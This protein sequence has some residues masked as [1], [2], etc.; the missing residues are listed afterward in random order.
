MVNVNWEGKGRW[1]EKCNCNQILGASNAL[2]PFKLQ[3]HPVRSIPERI[4]CVFLTSFITNLSTQNAAIKNLV[5]FNDTSPWNPSFLVP[6]LATPVCRELE[7]ILSACDRFTFAGVENN[8]VTK[9]I[10]KSRRRWSGCAERNYTAEIDTTVGSMTV[11]NGPSGYHFYEG[12][13]RENIGWQPF[14]HRGHSLKSVGIA[15]SPADV[16]AEP[17]FSLS[18]GTHLTA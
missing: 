5:N 14:I 18:N 15:S 10:V 2:L 17:V 1:W 4:S 12:G 11:I 6:R 9:P 3:L 8:G 7:S 13:G 16:S